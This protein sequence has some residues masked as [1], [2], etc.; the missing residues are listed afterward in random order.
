MIVVGTFIGLITVAGILIKYQ[1][2]SYNKNAPSPN[3]NKQQQQFTHPWP[4]QNKMI[5]LRKVW[6]Y[7][8]EPT[9]KW[10]TSTHTPQTITPRAH[11]KAL[12]I[13]NIGHATFL[14]QLANTNILTDPVFSNRAGPLGIFGPKRVVPPGL[15][16]NNLPNIDIAIISH[17]HYDHLDKFSVTTLA[18]HHEIT[19]VVPL[20]LKRTLQK[21]GITRPIIEIDWWES[22]Q[23]GGVKL[24]ATPA[25]HW[26]RRTLWDT[27]KTFW[28]GTLIQDIEEKHGHVYF[29]GDTGFGPHFKEIGERVNKLDVALLPIGSYEPRDIMKEQHINPYEAIQ[30]CKLLKANTLVPIHYDV[31][32][33]GAEPFKAAEAELQKHLSH[34][35]DIRFNT[36]ILPVGKTLPANP[37]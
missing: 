10:P 35:K 16:L 27:N 23:L 29:A 33:L 32:P 34:E 19:F 7:I 22:L 6:R 30:A 36:H 4:I 1:R 12:T 20:G 25:Q 11:C 3:W 28:M 21:W 14:I 9:T 8:L 2:Y 18:E 15:A 24:T 31:F 17:N 26:S 37:S 13:T 5:S